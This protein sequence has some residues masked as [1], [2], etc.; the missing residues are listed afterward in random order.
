MPT[1]HRLSASVDADLVA[2]G[3][4]AV[5]A[6]SADSLS[7]WVN[8]ALRRQTERDQRLLALGDFIAAYEAEN[9]A[10]TEAEIE[11]VSRAARARAT[12]VRGAPTR[13]A[14]G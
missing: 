3:N 12:V 7:A 14:A 5:A 2:A 11:D 6:G 1:K 13:S 10:I 8:G 4:A 9:G